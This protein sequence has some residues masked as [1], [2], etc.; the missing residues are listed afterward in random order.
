M[1]QR[2]VEMLLALLAGDRL[3]NPHLRL[4]TRLVVRG[5]TAAPAPAAPG[6]HARPAS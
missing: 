6:V 1:G 4:P 5:S 2:G 3:A